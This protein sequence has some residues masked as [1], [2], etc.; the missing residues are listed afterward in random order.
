MNLIHWLY[1]AGR[2]NEVLKFFLQMGEDNFSPILQTYMILICVFCESSM[3]LEAVKL[4][5]EMS[6]RS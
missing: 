2:I 1:E 5:G 3:K 4:F 6:G